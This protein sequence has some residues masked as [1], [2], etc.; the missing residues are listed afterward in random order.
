[1]PGLYEDIV[2]AMN[3]LH[4]AHPGFRAAHAKG[5]VARGSFTPSPRASELTTAAHLQ[6]DEV[7]VT[8]RFSNGSGD[9][10]ARDGDRRDGRGLAVK[11]ELPD[12]EAT[13]IVSVTLPVFFVKDAQSFLEFL[14]A[15][16]PDPETGDPDME[17]LGAFLGA[18]PETAAAVQLI[19]PA[20]SPPT[21]FATTRYNALHAFA[22]T[23]AEGETVHGRYSW[24]PEAGEE[25]L[26]ENEIDGSDRD[27]L[28]AE[29][30]ER[31][32]NGPVAFTLQLQI[33]GDGDL[34]E[35]PTV[36]WPAEREVVELGRLAIGELIED[37][38]TPDSPLVFDPVNVIEG[39]E[40]SDDEILEARSKAYSVSIERRTATA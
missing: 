26:P 24:I 14:H 18:H 37:P 12:G 38:E 9:P 17:K 39:I 21:S 35:D 22:F 32:G 33:A 15:R 40:C 2:D 28:E 6:G 3:A 30:R 1:M 19:L 36:A 34:L 4:G 13:D 29:I 11:F 23:N 31:L 25:L 16:E 20:L 8:V 5:T 7:P 10:E 27:Y